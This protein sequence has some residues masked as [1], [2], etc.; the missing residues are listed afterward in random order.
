MDNSFNIQGTFHERLDDVTFKNGGKK[1]E[2]VL[3]L[4]S[5]GKDGATYRDFPKFEVVEKFMPIIDSINVGDKVKVQFSI[6]GRKWRPEGADVDKYFSTFKAWDIVVLQK[7]DG[8]FVA[9][10]V[11]KTENFQDDSDPF[12][13][14][15]DNTDDDL[16]F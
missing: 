9:N 5:G 2:F 3:E 16:P 7:A 15:L 10:D 1:G 6:G 11:N 13:G 12:G 8:D 4:L 14:K